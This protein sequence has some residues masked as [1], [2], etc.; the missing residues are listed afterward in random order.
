MAAARSIATLLALLLAG[1]C[2]LAQKGNSPM[3]TPQTIA[4]RL[5]AAAPALLQGDAKALDRA[6]LEVSDT[7]FR[8]LAVLAPLQAGSGGG[9]PLVVVVQKSSLRGWEVGEEANLVLA[10]YDPDTGA[11]QAAPALVDRKALEFAPPD[12]QRPPRPPASAERTLMTKAYRFDAR[13]HLELPRR[14]GTLVLRA[15][16]WDWVSNGA[17]VELEGAA[18]RPVAAAAIEPLPA[19]AAGQLPIYE[20]SA[21]HP[22]LPAP[23]LA[24]A[25]EPMRDGGHVLLGSFAKPA[26]ARDL[27]AV[28][29]VLPTGS[30]P[31]GAVAAVRITLAALALD[32]PRPQVVRWAVPVW[33]SAAAVGQPLT[34]H[35][36]IDLRS[37]GA[38]RQPGRYALYLFMDEQVVGP[39]ML[40]VDGP[41]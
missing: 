40:S 28:P 2:S 23:G 21:R 3:T 36:A 12:L 14:Q 32:R 30:G 13:E 34:G 20:A 7:D 10:A 4:A 24:F 25:V 27:L 5:Q 8:G 22:P 6:E 11:L 1:G 26:A 38:V 16:A 33:G 9:L 41:R 31:R 35:F 19:V 39:V 17:R 15:L 37:S 18:P 29:Q